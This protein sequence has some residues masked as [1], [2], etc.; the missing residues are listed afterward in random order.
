MGDYTS[1]VI[2]LQNAINTEKFDSL[3]ESLNDLKSIQSDLEDNNK[4]T[5]SSI[6]K[7]TSKYPELIQYLGSAGDLSGALIS[8]IKDQQEQQESL[9]QSMIMATDGYYKDKI[10]SDEGASNELRAS[11]QSLV[12]DY[13]VK[14][15]VDLANY[16]NLE[17]AKIAITEACAK[18]VNSVW[19]KYLNVD[20]GMYDIDAYLSN[21]PITSTDEYN[22]LQVI[23]EANERRE[24]LNEILNGFAPKTIG[25]DTETKKA[26]SKS[27]SYISEG[28]DDEIERVKQG[29]EALTKE[30]DLLNNRIQL[31]ASKHGQDHPLVKAY[32][33]QLNDLLDQEKSLIETSANTLRGMAGGYFDVLK[34]LD[35]YFEQ[36][37]SYSEITQVQLSEIERLYDKK[38][39]NAGDDG[40]NSLTLQKGQI[41]E[42]VNAIIKAQSEVDSLGSD[43]FTN[44]SDSLDEFLNKLDTRVELIKAKFEDDNH[45]IELQMK[46]ADDTEDVE[47]SLSLTQVMIDNKI[48]LQEEYT[49]AY[50]DCLDRNLGEENDYCRNLKKLYME[51]ENDI[52]DYRVQMLEKQKAL[53]EDRINKISTIADA[54]QSALKDQV[55]KENE[56]YQKQKELLEDKK[57]AQ[58][59]YIDEQEKLL[60]NLKKEK[61]WRDKIAD[62]ERAF[63]DLVSNANNLEFAGGDAEMIQAKIQNMNDLKTAKDNLQDAYFDRSIEIQQDILDTLKESINNE[64]D[65]KIKAI[66]DKITANNNISDSDYRNKAYAMLETQDFD[67]ILTLLNGYYEE[68]GQ[69]LSGE[70]AEMMD[71]AKTAMSGLDVTTMKLIDNLQLLSTEAYNIQK[72]MQMVS[73][74]DFGGNELNSNSL[75]GQYQQGVEMI[76]GLMSSD[77]VKGFSDIITS[78]AGFNQQIT[79][80]VALSVPVNVN[81]DGNLDTEVLTK[82]SA[83]ISNTVGDVIESKL[84]KL[85]QVLNVA[86]VQ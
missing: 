80:D 83:I 30:I 5:T 37:K 19:E 18:S 43:W 6:E 63:A 16:R 81:V 14:Y 72:E 82:I 84:G 56:A 51:A 29:R 38:L 4:L 46:I 3:T 39:Q 31:T 48:A 1:A 60:D 9:Y 77:L 36:F 23:K 76:K 2:A 11:L 54:I 67:K 73:A 79:N 61:D 62:V 50:Q 45:A 70:I 44:A 47:K 85:G 40:K 7:L 22:D 32:R 8:K 86:K 28:L 57:Q 15:K 49:K 69:K 65:A 34:T 21:K 68:N 12:D 17:E 10:L 35:P 64:Y 26:S 59:D 27:F 42:Y 58:L 20:T 33:E 52:Y 55:A 71:G 66:E 78:F 75:E 53:K 25:I 13:G 74:T 41:Q 24:R